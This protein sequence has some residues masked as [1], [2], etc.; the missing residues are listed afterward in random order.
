MMTIQQMQQAVRQCQDICNQLI[1]Q[2]Q[3]NASQLNQFNHGSLQNMSQVESGAAQQL[4]RLQQLCAQIEQNLNMLA[5]S[6][7]GIGAGAYA[8]SPSA[9]YTTPY[10]PVYSGG[11]AQG[12]NPTAFQQVMQADRYSEAGPSQPAAGYSQPHAY[13]WHQI[14]A[15]NQSAVQQVLQADRNQGESGPSNPTAGYGYSHPT[16]AG[17]YSA[18]GVNASALQQVMR[19]DHQQG[20]AG[21]TPSQPVGSVSA[22]PQQAYGYTPHYYGQPVNTGAISQV[23]QAASRAQ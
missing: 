13:G 18:P 15:V 22:S 3:R 23:M 8:A 4:R 21:T 17:S 14:P 6:Q 5:S 10:A 1:A 11:M 2:E 12:I 9:H 7:P 19:A 16:P 20:Q